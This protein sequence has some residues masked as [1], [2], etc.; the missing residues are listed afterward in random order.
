[1]PLERHAIFLGVVRA[2]AVII[3]RG[4]EMSMNCEPA[5]LETGGQW[6]RW[7]P[8]NPPVVLSSEDEADFLVMSG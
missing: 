6:H 4:W 7:N 5:D 8:G 1:M 2:A 3:V